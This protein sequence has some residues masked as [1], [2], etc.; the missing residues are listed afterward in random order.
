MLSEIT[1]SITLQI[2]SQVQSSEGTSRS[3][4]LRTEQ[5]QR[6]VSAVLGAAVRFAVREEASPLPCLLLILGFQHKLN[7]LY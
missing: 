4:G 2:P 3:P 5:P 7:R 6:P 1:F